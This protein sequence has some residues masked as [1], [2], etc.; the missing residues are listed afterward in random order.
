MSV[1][2]RNGIYCQDDVWAFDR[3]QPL[4]SDDYSSV[5][6]LHQR[7]HVRERRDRHKWWVSQGSC[8]IRQS[9]INAKKEKSEADYMLLSRCLFLCYLFVCIFF[10]WCHVS[11]ICTK[12]SPFKVR[13]QC[14]FSCL[15]HVGIIQLSWWKEHILWQSVHKTHDEHTSCAGLKPRPKPGPHL[16][17]ST[18]CG[19]VVLSMRISTDAL[20]FLHPF[21]NAATQS[22]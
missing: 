11:T 10:F 9:P 7:E 3:K 14:C 2:A 20:T 17:I 12:T 4:I 19:S 21:S 18:Y 13:K 15:Q 16:P 22:P 5:D 6:M 8:S 1:Y